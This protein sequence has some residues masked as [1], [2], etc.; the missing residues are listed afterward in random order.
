MPWV[1]V[2][3]Y[4]ITGVSIISNPVLERKLKSLHDAPAGLDKAKVHGVVVAM[5]SL[6]PNSWRRSVTVLAEG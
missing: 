3:A 5:L 6:W 2:R 1:R 4:R